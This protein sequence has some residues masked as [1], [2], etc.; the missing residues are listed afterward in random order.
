MG[1]ALFYGDT[2]RF[3]ICKQMLLAEKLIQRFWPNAIGQRTIKVV[4]TM[5]LVSLACE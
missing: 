1:T 3:A 5:G 4:F 2:Q